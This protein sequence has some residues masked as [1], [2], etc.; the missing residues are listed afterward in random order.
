[1]GSNFPTSIMGRDDL[2]KDTPLVAVFESFFNSNYDLTDK[3]VEFY[4]TAFTGLHRFLERVLRRQP[5]LDDFSRKSVEAYLM[6]LGKDPT[7]K[8]PK[9]SPFRTRAA[10]SSL[11]RLGNWLAEDGVH[12]DKNG[13]SLLKGVRKAKEPKDVRQPLSDDELEAV[14][15]AAGRSG[16]RDYTLIVFAAG[17][18]LRLNEL[19]EARVGDLDRKNW[20][21]TVRAEISKVDRSRVVDIHPAVAKELDR[22][23]RQRPVVRDV[24]PLFP[25]DEGAVFT[26][27]GFQKVF[28]R[29]KVG[30]GVTLFSCH[31]LRHTWATRFGGDVLALKKQ[32][33]WLDWK[34]VERYRHAPAVARDDLVDPVNVQGRSL[35]PATITPMRPGEDLTGAKSAFGQVPVARA[36]A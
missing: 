1:M 28:K 22:Y 30:S 17:T 24:D 35:R 14:R 32:G 36:R 11:K 8:Y 3:T 25:S 34:Q 16:E 9:G 27:S 6:W 29:I 10:V 33:G 21:H 7:P 5:V 23:L 2:R 12:S 26:N 31:L 4:Q 15:N 13:L 20:T 19:R 18:G